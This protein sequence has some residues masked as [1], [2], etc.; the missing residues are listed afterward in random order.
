MYTVP[1]TAKAT[2]KYRD[3]VVRCESKPHSRF[4][5]NYTSEP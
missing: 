5:W 2:Y 1:T 4:L 3:F